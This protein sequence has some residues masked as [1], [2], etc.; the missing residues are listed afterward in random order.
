MELFSSKGV[1]KYLSNT[2]FLML[3]KVLRIIV[4]LT[5]W[6]AVAR[7]LG[8]ERFG[9]FNYA[10]S[11][12]F[13]FKILA[14]LG[15]DYIVV[16]EVIKRP[17]EKKVILGTSFLLKFIGSVTA[18]I[19]I[20]VMTYFMDL[21]F[22]TQIVVIL[23]SLRLIFYSFNIIDFYFRSQV[24]SK[25]GVFAQL[26]SLVSTSILCTVFIILQK[27]IIYFALVVIIEFFVYAVGLMYFY[28]RREKD[29]H[30]WQ[31]DGHVAKNLIQDAWPI[32]VSG[33]AI[34]IYMRIDQVM[35]KILLNTTSVGYYSAAVRISEAFY[36]LPVIIASSFFPAIVNAKLRNERIYQERLQIL[37]TFLLWIS[38]AIA[39]L[40][41]MISS[42]LVNFIYGQE[43]A[44]SADALIIH[45]WASLF[46]FLGVIRGKW[47]INE[48]LQIYCMFYGIFGAISNIALNALLIPR[49]GIQGSAV[50]TVLSQF[51]AAVLSNLFS[52]KT[53]KI[54]YM[55]CKA[56][57][58][59]QL[60]GFLITFKNVIMEK[61][62]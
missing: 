15:M 24:L 8:P 7:Y 28:Q 31:F 16:R 59:L 29:I 10:L 38:I 35:L 40:I 1:K 27:S 52:R 25:F 46:V 19:T 9:I 56:L 21:Q 34:A 12:V 44:H 60:R 36:F 26:F 49:I 45:I 50:A 2:G 23:I 39:V 4:G 20:G 5:V 32:I 42:P 55:Q 30:H 6:A 48:N 13:L 41:T 18:V 43:Y 37:F 53:R 51:N 61:Y 17:A 57:N 33:I 3:E 14:D 58:F 47:A 22:V 62:T 54:F 11:F